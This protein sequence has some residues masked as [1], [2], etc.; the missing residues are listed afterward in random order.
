M[1]PEQSQEAYPYAT[2]SLVDPVTEP[3]QDRHR[4]TFLLVS[5]CLRAE[6]SH[7]GRFENVR[8][9]L[10]HAAVFNMQQL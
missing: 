6:R 3:H 2:F 4:G 5:Y 1:T 9:I 7:V 8:L 10:F